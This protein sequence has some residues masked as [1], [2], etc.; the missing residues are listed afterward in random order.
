MTTILL[1]AR[2][3]VPRPRAFD[4][5]LLK[6]LVFAHPTWS[7][8]QLAE[9]LTAEARKGDPKAPEVNYKT[10][11]VT[12]SRLKPTWEAQAGIKLPTRMVPLLDFMPPA[13]TIHPEHRMDTP[14]RYMREIAKDA[15]GDRPKEPRQVAFRISA[16]NWRDGTIAAGE[17]LDLSSKGVPQI[18]IANR[19][20]READGTTKAIA[21]WLLPGW[22]GGE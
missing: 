20:E 6:R 12:I 4:R 7:D 17:I 22:R 2:G 15:R 19:A 3:P 21:A 16:L 18:R 5:D 10:V 9:A 14:I 8:R 11:S 13:N 1:Q